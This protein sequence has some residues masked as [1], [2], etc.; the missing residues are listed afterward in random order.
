MWTV[1]EIWTGQTA[2]IVAGGPSVADQPTERLRGRAVVVVNSSYERVPFAPFLFFGDNRWWVL[3]KPRLAMWSGTIVTCAGGASGRVE[4][5]YRYDAAQGLS[6][7][8]NGVVMGRTSL[9]GA[10][11]LATLLGARRLVL[12]GADMGAAP[13]GA[14]HHHEPHPW[15]QRPGCW[16]EQMK[17]LEPMVPRLVDQGVEVLNASPVSRLPWWRKIDLESEL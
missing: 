12:L 15:P 5:L 1:P 14:T 9:Q 6:T 3:H 4:R 10:M 13:T 2:F 8:P 17:L 16:D 11:N 7:N